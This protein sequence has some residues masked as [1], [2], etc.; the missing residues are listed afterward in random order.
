MKERLKILLSVQFSEVED[1][2]TASSI[3][4]YDDDGK[5]KRAFYPPLNSIVTLLL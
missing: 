5:S 2:Q 1:N 4:A 3:S